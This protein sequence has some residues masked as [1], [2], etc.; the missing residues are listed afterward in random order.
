MLAISPYSIDFDY[1]GLN[2]LGW[3]YRLDA[4][5]SGVVDE[6][7]RLRGQCEA[8]PSAELIK[9]LGGV[10][11]K[12]W[13]YHYQARTTVA[14]QKGSS[15]LRAD[16][17]SSYRAHALK[18]FTHGDVEEI[19]TTLSLRPAPWYGEAI[20]PFLL[21]LAGR[22]LKLPFFLTLSR[23]S[24]MDGLDEPDV[25]EMPYFVRRGTLVRK[26]SIQP[27]SAIAR[28]IARF[29][30]SEREAALAVANRDPRRLLEALRL[31]PWTGPGVYISAMVDEIRA[32]RFV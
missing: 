4:A 23:A 18:V 10:P 15:L 7:I 2:H 11:T 16:F 22:E 27:P 26:Q 6:Y 14:Q 30:A 13:R 25:F 3:F 1:C 12:Y 8:F 17:L 5:R 21:A 9:G 32:A 28:L 29:L 24:Q 20:A 19:R 31:H